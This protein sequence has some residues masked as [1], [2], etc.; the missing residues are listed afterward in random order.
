MKKII[1][2][3]A[4]QRI[5]GNI[6]RARSAKVPLL[7]IVMVAIIGFAMTAL[8][9]IGCDKDGGRGVSVRV[10]ASNN[11]GIAPSQAMLARNTQSMG[12]MSV[13]GDTSFAEFN[14][15]YSKIGAVVENITPTEFILEV[16][17]LTLYASNGDSLA[18]IENNP[19]RFD[20]TKGLTFDL[21]DIPAGTTL[22]AMQFIISPEG[23]ETK[24]TF[25]VPDDIDVTNP[26]YNNG[27]PFWELG[28]YSDSNRMLSIMFGYIDPAWMIRNRILFCETDH[29]DNWGH[30][31]YGNTYTESY[32]SDVNIQQLHGFYYA[33]NTRKVYNG[34]FSANELVP[35]A[36]VWWDLGAQ[37]RDS[38]IIPLNP[39]T[40]H[41]STNSITFD[42]SWDLNGI[43]E[44]RQGATTSP[45]DDIFV[46]KNDWWNSLHI[47]V[48]VQ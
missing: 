2:H 18:L 45:N 11:N 17:N 8:S 7:I 12:L 40:V 23:P 24:V 1:K 27:H 30:T 38:I 47:S 41:S 37:D 10:R 4:I 13:V 5:A 29:H 34:G 20:F 14:K 42:I 3:K 25:R 39:V 28:N 22:V 21:G 31:C 26:S 44:R 33:G 43:V 19:R 46:L 48:N 9:L 16:V 35:S 15:F 6:N 32:F 36:P